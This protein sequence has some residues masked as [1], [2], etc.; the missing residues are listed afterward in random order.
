[1]VSFVNLAFFLTASEVSCQIEGLSNS[2]LVM[3]G[4]L[5]RLQDDHVSLVVVAA[6]ETL[7]VLCRDFQR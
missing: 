4:D 3:S 1:M 5:I 7:Y 2:A 6:A